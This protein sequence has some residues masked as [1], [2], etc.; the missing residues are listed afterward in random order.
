[1]C[2]IVEVVATAVLK[3]QKMPIGHVVWVIV[4]SLV[5]APAFMTSMVITPVIMP[6]NSVAYAQ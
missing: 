5:A 6:V 1:M 4:N 2:L 3:G